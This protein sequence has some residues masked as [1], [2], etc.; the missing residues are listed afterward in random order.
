M[1]LSLPPTTPQA[2]PSRTNDPTSAA[3]ASSPESDLRLAALE[4]LVNSVR[5]EPYNWSAWLKI[6]ECLDGP[7]EVSARARSSNRIRPS[8]ASTDLDSRGVAPL[9]QLEA[10]MPF[11]P[12][13]YPLLFFYVHCSLEI[14][15][16]NDVLLDIVDELEQ[17]FGRE[18]APVTGMRA[19]VH[20]HMRGMAFDPHSQRQQ[21][22]YRPSFLSG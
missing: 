9:S 20:Y 15:A 18:C 12:S 22:P 1:F 7:E 13:C 8:A 11:L 16:A 21:E 10:T 19:L 6:A 2:F 14:H 3:A 5:A 17:V 4:T